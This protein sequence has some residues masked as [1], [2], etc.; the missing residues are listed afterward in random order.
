MHESKFQCL[1]LTVRIRSTYFGV[2]YFLLEEHLTVYYTVFE[3]YE[4]AGRL[5]EF[6]PRRLTVLDIRLDLVAWSVETTR[7][8]DRNAC[9]SLPLA[10]SDK[11][12]PS[13]PQVS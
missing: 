5:K 2:S 7:V 6:S 11:V 12:A 10:H 4:D 8:L 13:R 1:Q 9:H 3:F